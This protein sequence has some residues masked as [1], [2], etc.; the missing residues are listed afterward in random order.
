MKQHVNLYRGRLLPK[1]DPLPPLYL[2][3][4]LAVG[5]MLAAWDMWSARQVLQSAKHRLEVAQRQQAL[6]SEA[7][8]KLQ[9]EIPAPDWRAR[10]EA[11]IMQLQRDLARNQATLAALEMWRNK[12]SNPFSGILEDLATLNDPKLWLTGIGI[13]PSGLRLEGKTTEPARVGAM[14]QVLQGLPHTQ[15][16]SYHQVVIDKEKPGDSVSQ[17]WVLPEGE[18]REQPE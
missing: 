10:A 7:L 18:E 11:T 9:A 15:G 5:L 1:P 16:M 14:I 17:F 12:S 2:V 3:L 8:E 6:G 4:A 13:L